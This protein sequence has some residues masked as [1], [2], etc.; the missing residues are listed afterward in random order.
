MLI[1]YDSK[2]GNV[3]R[4]I[5]KLDMNAIR[6]EEDLILSE[7]FILV[8]YTTNFGQVPKKTASFLKN[9]HTNLIG[10]ASSGNKNWG[11]NFCKSAVKISDMYRIPIVLK[12]ELSGTNN[13]VQKFKDEVAKIE[14]HRTKQ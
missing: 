13:D 9:N 1:A 10:V 5:N 11:D 6:I 14:S 2:T 7:P 4:F 8:T 12:F 3:Q